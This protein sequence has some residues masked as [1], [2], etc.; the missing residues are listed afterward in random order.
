MSTALPPESQNPGGQPIAP[1]DS[2]ARRALYDHLWAYIN[3]P[4]WVWQENTSQVVKIDIF[5]VPPSRER[6][7]YTLLTAG[8]SDLPMP[9]D[10]T[11]ND[12]PLYAEFI[13]ALPEEWPL[14]PDD[15]DDEQYF[16]PIRWL[17]TLARY[18]HL[19]QRA[20]GLL[21]TL[22]NGE[23]PQP[24]APG[25][26]YCGWLIS[27]PMLAER[28]FAECEVNDNKTIHIYSLLPLY[29]GEMAFKQS[30][31]GVS[32]VERLGRV[33]AS[34]LIDPERPDVSML[35]DDKGDEAP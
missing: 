23:P 12:E 6:P 26:E 7:Y 2:E 10:G 5:V 17:K 18:P 35:D 25:T 15:W 31:D 8:M 33:G 28:D 13:I 20:L 4:L 22:P 34:E 3:K 21:H 16:W 11:E 1:V 9:S 29:A 30:N 32:L 27:L 14:H 19:R 24:F